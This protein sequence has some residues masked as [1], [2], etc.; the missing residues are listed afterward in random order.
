MISTDVLEHIP[1]EDIGWVL[2][3]LFGHAGKFVYVVAACYP[4]KK[5]MPDGT[6][7]HCTLQSPTW[8]EGQMRMAAARNPGVSWA[9]RAQEKSAFAFEQRRKLTR[10]GVRS[11]YFRG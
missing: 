6:N 8:W 10:K 11:L 9:S 7:A 5:I 1:E 3:D 4:A 2:D